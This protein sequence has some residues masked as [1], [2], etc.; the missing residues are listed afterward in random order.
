M[1][2]K[3][4][5]SKAKA[6]ALWRNDCSKRKLHKVCACTPSTKESHS[7]VILLT[8][9][10]LTVSIG[11]T[12]MYLVLNGSIAILCNECSNH[13]HSVQCYDTMSMPSHS[14]HVA[15][16]HADNQYPGHSASDG[17]LRFLVITDLANDHQDAR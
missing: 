17:I 1:S 9:G 5:R 10:T 12:A 4:C 13:A 8:M 16:A 14:W 7:A 2:E 11:V 6:H 15:R 3:K